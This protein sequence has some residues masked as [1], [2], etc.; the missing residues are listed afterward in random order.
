MSATE[1][2]ITD[3][4]TVMATGKGF[5]ARPR[6]GTVRVRLPKGAIVTFPDGTEDRFPDKKLKLVASSR[7]PTKPLEPLPESYRR[8]ASVE[9]SPAIFRA[10]ELEGRPI[11]P[12]VKPELA[13]KNPSYMEWIRCKP[14]CNCQAPP[15][16]DPHHHGRHALSRK[17]R[18][19]KCVPLCR[20]CHNCF[21]DNGTLPDPEASQHERTLIERTKAESQ[22][23]LQRAQVECL[24][25]AWALMPS[26]VPREPLIDVLSRELARLG[27]S[28]LSERLK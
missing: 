15:R 16:S 4:S 24:T 26:E 11:V 7:A 28:V 14:C 27:E 1:G 13:E 21:T 22:V 18:D 10:S 25:E 20:T 5:G 23:I 6:Q 9:R 2:E 17:V 19:T 3:G 12:L 8:P